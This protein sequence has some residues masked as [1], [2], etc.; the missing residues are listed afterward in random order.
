MFVLR[1]N[2]TLIGI[3]FSKTSVGGGQSRKLGELPIHEFFCLP[4]S[5]DNIPPRAESI[6]L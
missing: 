3:I 4:I 1:Y 6:L 2:F 5:R